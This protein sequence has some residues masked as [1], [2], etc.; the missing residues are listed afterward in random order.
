MHSGVSNAGQGCDVTKGLACS[1]FEDLGCLQRCQ[2]GAHS[3]LQRAVCYV[4]GLSNGHGRAA[5]CFGQ[6]VLQTGLQ[7]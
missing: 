6:H 7:Q 5:N 1:G 4:S 2:D 3:V